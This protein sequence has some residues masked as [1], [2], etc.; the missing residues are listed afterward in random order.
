LVLDGPTPPAWQVGVAEALAASSYVILTAVRTTATSR[1]QSV[2]RLHRAVERRLFNFSPDPTSPTALSVETSTLSDLPDCTVWLAEATPPENET[3]IV[4]RYGRWLEHARPAFRRAAA[5]GAAVVQ[6]QAILHQPGAPPRVLAQGTTGVRAY[7]I[8]VGLN[9]ALWRSVTIV[10]RA[11]AAYAG[12]V[13]ASSTA[14]ETSARAPGGPPFSDKAVLGTAALRWLRVLATRLLFRRP[15]RILIREREPEPL[16]GWS[17]K[18]ALVRWKAGHVYADPFLFEHDGRHHLF[19][20]EVPEG[21]HR[22]IISHTELRH[23]SLAEPPSPVLVANHHL[24]YPFVFTY[25]GTVFMVPETLGAGRV[26]LH[27]A[28][29]FPN[30]WKLDSVLLDGVRAADA[31]LFEHG[32]QWWLFAAM[33]GNATTVTD[34]LHAFFADSPRGPWKPHP[35]NP[36]VADVRA[37]RPAGAVFRDGGRLIRP[38]QDSSRRYGWA[39]TFR[40]IVMLTPESYEE[41]CLGRLE[42]RAIS[43]AR[44]VHHYARDSR[45]EAID[46]R[47]RIPR[48]ALAA[49]LLD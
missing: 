18:E 24:S 38:A 35:Q 40:E 20:E 49:R 43:G 9:M 39:L 33:G 42:P 47:R 41:R 46:I 45:Y 19:C 14:G 7:S 31:T 4:V 28:V 16:S 12:A 29:D 30:V 48:L 26:E 3:V 36:V 1:D 32:D 23:G 10:E 22:G 8:G 2:W 6:T 34:A 15:W 13:D 27:R 25:A 37:A 44:A 21:S 11:V 17:S 5:D